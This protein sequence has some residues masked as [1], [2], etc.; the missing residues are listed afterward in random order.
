MSGVDVLAVMD[1]GQAA[2]LDQLALEIVASGAHVDSTNI[3]EAAEKA[4]QAREA[5]V[6]TL[7]DSL[8]SRTFCSSD[9]E[10]FLDSF[11]HSIYGAAR[12]KRINS[13]ESANAE[14]LAEAGNDLPCK[15]ER[16]VRAANSE[17][18]A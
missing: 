9:N 11:F 12:V 13:R 18:A 14:P 15:Q 6:S 5:R 16:P 1:A 10:P 3:L 8:R 2:Y 17:A 7:I 4:H